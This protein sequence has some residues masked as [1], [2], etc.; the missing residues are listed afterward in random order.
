MGI[1]RGRGG[2]TIFTQPTTA[3][4]ENLSHVSCP[5]HTPSRYRN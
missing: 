1:D 4:N 3:I 5:P 2:G